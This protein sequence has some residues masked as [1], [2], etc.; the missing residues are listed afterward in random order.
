MSYEKVTQAKDRL[1]IGIKQASKTMKSGEVSQIVV[2][3]DID[4]DLK[5]KILGL[6]DQLNIPY[7]LVESKKRLGE[8][9]GIEVGTAVVAIKQ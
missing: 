9:C 1:V 4:S 3:T 8:A 7:E 2:A 6:A 5:V